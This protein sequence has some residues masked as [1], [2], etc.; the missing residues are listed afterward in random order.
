MPVASQETHPQHGRGHLRRLR[1][2]TRRVLRVLLA[3]V[4]GAALA[5]AGCGSGDPGVDAVVDRV[6]QQLAQQVVPVLAAEGL[7][8]AAMDAWD[9]ALRDAR[10]DGLHV[11][12]GSPGGAQASGGHAVI[13]SVVTIVGPGRGACVA[14]AASS[15][16][17][18]RS[19]PVRGEPAENCDG[20]ELP[21]STP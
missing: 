20:A 11:V 12:T 16:G 19:M 1:A 7:T 21:D 18:V 3:G 8:D 6:E 14:V 10:G 9:E 5:L 13:E 17:T 15:D 2:G 4:G